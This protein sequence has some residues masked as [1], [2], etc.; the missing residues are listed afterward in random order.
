MII[1][2]DIGAT[3]LKLV[4]KKEDE[5]II[6]I[7]KNV[8]DI[9]SSKEIEKCIKIILEENSIQLQDIK[10]IRLTGAKSSFIEEKIFDIKPVLIGEFEA[11]KIGA[12]KATGLKKAIVVN[13]GTGTTFI[14]VKDN[15]FKHI[16]GSGLGG[17]TIIGLNNGESFEKIYE[18]ALLGST[19]NVDLLI[20]DISKNNIGNLTGDL[21]C[22]NFGKINKANSNDKAAGIFNMVYQSIAVM[23]SLASITEDVKDIIFIG[24]AIDNDLAKSIINKVINMYNKIAHFP[25]DSGFVVARGCI[26]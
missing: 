6:Q 22:S 15:L 8:V 23:A 13:C 17:G 21:V 9:V 7:K 10:E 5:E 14:F 1:G 24:N 4:A 20:K 18:K 26:S 16:G 19:D 12:Q 3:L 2:I 25:S 11:A